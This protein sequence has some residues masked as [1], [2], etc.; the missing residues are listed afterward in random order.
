[1]KTEHDIEVWVQKQTDRLDARYMADGSTMTAEQYE[2]ALRCIDIEASQM[3]R[4]IQPAPF[5][6]DFR[7]YS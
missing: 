4:G 5:R 3:Y 2:D 7:N 6:E 1:M